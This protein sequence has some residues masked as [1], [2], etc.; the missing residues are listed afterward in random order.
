MAVS[1]ES[2][3]PNHVGSGWGQFGQGD[4]GALAAQ[5]RVAVLIHL[6][7]QQGGI[8]VTHME[9]WHGWGKDGGDVGEVTWMG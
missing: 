8:G 9:G 2:L 3:D 6:R 5:H 1:G 7:T 4:R